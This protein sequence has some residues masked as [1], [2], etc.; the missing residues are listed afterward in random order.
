MS[1]N[2]SML[3]EVK[4]T[5]D[6]AKMKLI[7]SGVFKNKGKVEEFEKAFIEHYN[8]TRRSKVRFA[9]FYTAIDILSEYVDFKKISKAELSDE[10]A[11]MID[12]FKSKEV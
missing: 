4:D 1:I 5:V 10:I 7:V 6:K 2:L 12:R 8:V 3:Q 9:T 11:G